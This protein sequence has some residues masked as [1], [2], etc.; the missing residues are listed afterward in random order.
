M[1]GFESFLEDLKVK[2]EVFKN[3]DGDLTT[4]LV[5]ILFED[6]RLSAEF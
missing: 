1:K 3:I 2:F 6:M 5:K 4:Y